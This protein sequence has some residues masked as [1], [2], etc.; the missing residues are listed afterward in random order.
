MQN[1]IFIMNKNMDYR[2]RWSDNLL[3]RAMK[4][5][6]EHGLENTCCGG[7][8]RRMASSMMRGAAPTKEAELELG[9]MKV[10]RGLATSQHRPTASE[11]LA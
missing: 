5:W 10:A 1:I 6:L 2:P 9:A 11:E 4:L 3:W 7:W 8:R